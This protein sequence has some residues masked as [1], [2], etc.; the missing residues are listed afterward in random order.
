MSP[1]L[2]TDL[3]SATPFRVTFFYGRYGAGYHIGF[4]DIARGGW[5][6]IICRTPDEYLTACNNLFREVFVLAHTQHLKNKDIYEGGSKL[7]VI[8]D[9][10]DLETSE[11][12]SRHLHKLQFGFIHAFFDIFVTKNGIARDERVVDYYR[13]DEPIEIGPDENLHNDMIEMI[14]RLSVNRGYILGIG[15]ISSKRVGINHK[16]YGVTSRGVVQAAQIALKEI[17][18]D[19]HKD[20]FTVKMTGGPNGDVA[21]NSMKLLLQHCPNVKILSIVD[22]SGGLF[23]AAGINLT[24]LGRLISSDDID[25]FPPTALNPGGFIL[26]RNERK[27]EGFRQ[28]YRKTVRNHT[29]TEDHWITADEFHREITELTFGTEA[30]L[31]LPCGGRPETIHANNWKLLLSE[32]GIPNTRV[33]VEGANSFIT[34]EARIY[35]QKSGVVLLRDAT[36]NKGGV[37]SS[38]YEIIA[39][40]LLHE[41]EFFRHK[42][43]YVTDV[44]DILKRRVEE[45]V[46]LIF[47]RFHESRESRLYT[48]I[49]DDISREI[50]GHY[51]RIFEYFQQKK[52][53]VVESIFLKTIL[54]HLPDFIRNNPRYRTRI[55]N[56][57]PKIMSAILAVEL[58]TA[59]VY[60]GGWELDF[61]NRL[62]TFAK[63]NLTSHRTER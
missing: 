57:P 22:G 60:H 56:L 23:D 55:R 26:F 44:I 38:S 8:L 3:P 42:E 53:V 39:N 37:I 58:A 5:R 30:D 35:L 11:A 36:A 18:I 2:L 25:H 52:H 14:S 45:E 28:L 1:E 31:F 17:Q 32:T 29:A 46:A 50:N 41:K 9:A 4:S 20:P 12:V 15:I 13:E 59:I 27:L 40:L 19:I 16:A 10:R 43:A 54:R 33:I 47:K 61:E 34:P 51:A 48:E 6:T 21:G 62:K 24:E 63:D 49:S 7:T